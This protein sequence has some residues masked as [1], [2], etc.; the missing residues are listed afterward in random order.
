[1]RVQGRVVAADT[2]DPVASARVLAIDDPTVG[3]PPPV[4]T[5]ALGRPLARGHAAGAAIEEAPVVGAAG[6]GPVATDA[7]AGASALRLATRTGLSAGAVVAIGPVGGDYA[8]VGRVADPGPPPLADPGSVTLRDPLTQTIRAGSAADL[9]T[10]GNGT[11]TTLAA[12]TEPGS[13]VVVAD[14][15]VVGLVRVDP[16]PDEEYRFVGVV[17]DGAGFYRLDGLAGVLSLWLAAEAAGFQQAHQAVTVRYGTPVT[18]VDFQ[19]T[20]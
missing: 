1:M 8:E 3:T 14:A 19:L 12:A 20:P 18:V 2:G 7:P 15:P 13:A 6:L 10:L 5:V 16:G 9:L 11:A 17:A 4:H